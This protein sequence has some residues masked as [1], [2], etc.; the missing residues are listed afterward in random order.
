MEPPVS[1]PEYETPML[2]SAPALRLS[3]RI[4]CDPATSGRRVHPALS[5]EM[6]SI[7]TFVPSPVTENE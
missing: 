3:M 1:G 7:Q 5:Q 6:L 4:E 2:V